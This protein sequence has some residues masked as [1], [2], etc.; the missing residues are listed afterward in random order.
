VGTAC[1]V[2]ASHMSC[3]RERF[4]WGQELA[5]SLVNSQRQVRE[6]H[7]EVGVWYCEALMG[8]G[9]SSG[10]TCECLIGGGGIG[11]WVLNYHS[12]GVGTSHVSGERVLE[13]GAGIGR[14]T[15]ELATAGV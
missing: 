4:S 2:H 8:S 12:S 3:G 13:L 10:V 11:C 9:S 14:F 5:A 1:E 15:G 6:M 7:C